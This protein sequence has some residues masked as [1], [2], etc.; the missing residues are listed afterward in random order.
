MADSN[1]VLQLI[2]TA[3]DEISGVFGKV[4]GF[5]DRTT[6]ATA[7]LIREKFT[8][9]FGGGLD[10]AIEF[11]AQLDRVAAKGGYTQEAMIQLGS[12]ARQIG[13][14]FGISGTEAAKGMEALAAAGLT[15]VDAIRTLPS[16]LALASA[17]QISA[18]AAAQ[19]LSDSL[20]IMG[21][22]FEEAGRMADVLAKGAN[23]TTS[24]ASQLAEALSEAGG[25]ARAAGMDLETTVAALDLL[26]K[27]G[28]KGSEAGTALKGILTSLQDPASKASEE[29]SKLG[30]STRTL[31]GVLDALKASGGAANAAILAF[32]TEA[33]PGLRALLSE[34]QDGL[35]DYTNQ[36]KQSGGAAEEAARLMSGNLK[37]AMASLAS[38][39]ETVKA[40]LLEPALE[41]LAEAARNTA[42][43]L[44]ESLGS[45][46]FKSVQ[47]AIQEF[48]TQGIAA[49][50]KF[51]AA[52][53]FSR[54]G[55]AIKAFADDAKTVFS[56]LA[57]AAEVT[58]N[59]IK[60]AWN[61]V[62]LAV[63]TVAI[64][65]AGFT[66]TIATS[67]ET[68]IIAMEKVGLVSAEAANKVKTAAD[69]SRAGVLS[70][71]NGIEQ[72][73]AD[74]QGA[75]QR[76][77]GDVDQT[78]DKL[79]AIIPKANEVRDS[80]KDIQPPNFG[81]AAQL[82]AFTQDLDYYKVRLRQAKDAQ[83]EAAAAAR[84]AEQTYADVSARVKE[85][86]VGQGSYELALQKVAVAHQAEKA[87][88]EQVLLARSNLD[89]EIKNS[90]SRIDEESTSVT[91]NIVTKKAL[92]EQ[93]KLQLETAGKILDAQ[94][95]NYA[96]AV[97]VAQAE[98][99]LAQ[100][101]GDQQAAAEA[102]LKVAEAELAALEKKRQAEENELE[103]YRKIGERIAD[104]TS[105]KGA[106]N[107]A[108]EAE[109]AALNQKYPAIASEIS[110]REKN[111]EAIGI[112][113]EK[114]Q[115]EAQQAA[116]MAGPIGDLTRLY[117]EQTA[118]HERAASAA[119]RYYDTQIAEKD[120]AISVAKAKGDEATAA[121]LLIE[122]Q[123]LEIEKAAALSA[124][125]AQAAADA[126]NAV[127]AKKL[128]AAASEGISEVEQQEIDKLQEVADAKKAAAEQAAIHAEAMREEADAAEEST[129]AFDNAAQNAYKFS[130]A[131]ADVAKRNA[132]V[133]KS[134]GSGAEEMN[135][136][137]IAVAEFN[138]LSQ[139]GFGT[140]GLAKYNEVIEDIQHAMT[141]ANVLA[142]RL[143]DEGMAAANGAVDLL[144][145]SLIDS[146]SY[147]NEAA[148]AAGENLKDALESAREAAAD[149]RDELA[150]VAEDYSQK[151]FELT[152][153]EVEVME[154]ER[155]AKLAELK[156]KYE[157][158][159]TAASQAYQDAKNAVMEY[160]RIKIAQERAD[161]EESTRTTTTA[162]NVK[163]AWSGAADE[164]ERAKTALAGINSADLNNVIG[165]IGKV[166]GA[167]Q[168]LRSV[169]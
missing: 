119:E 55:P 71:R 5:V 60:L 15:A 144:A 120:A 76:L 54:V 141:E 73:V 59:G 156:A 68:V 164:I 118:E 2:L 110:Q 42:T 95:K 27:N 153:S 37:S 89:A 9:L 33:G 106:L 159:G 99:A 34:G 65:L 82:Q 46:A 158:A 44:Q 135:K 80:I 29:L 96:A 36:L 131:A 66:A 43:A 24:S 169:L 167:A 57:G 151:I 53:D 115:L 114:Q 52:F 97:A 69:A 155:D 113:I 41:P 72:D 39:W 102:S 86:T 117:R 64:T 67:V 165:Q 20:S 146:N 98:L 112:Q 166:T 137:N 25:M 163:D 125:K 127:D 123:D 77:N 28:I 100:A 32:G 70:L 154:A 104:L 150:G 11:E 91:N 58:A 35:T 126:Q 88:A 160:Y 50:E 49:V 143:A 161:A 93:D 21:M 139:V 31:G 81:D 62:T 157:L 74:M 17:E 1:L 109:L 136:L 149:L 124:A 26:H 79:A 14:D 40:S 116:I 85:G 105:R 83:T 75:W 129:D 134:A 147:L 142:Q 111:V 90:I 128:E 6:S 84:I 152:A 51:L 63:R 8:D 168:Q 7:N 47:A 87:A 13:A 121:A 148:H 56:E 3:K 16:V 38:T 122:K 12:A 22:G 45:R 19:K 23:I 18:D 108:D 92:Y 103:L 132:E 162:N 94:E 130:D 145:Q 140:E 61:G 133:G 101:K 10:G 30:I 4:F 138:G 78:P 107:Y 48:V